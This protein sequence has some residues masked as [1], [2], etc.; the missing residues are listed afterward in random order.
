[1]GMQNITMLLKADKDAW[2]SAV[3]P[4]PCKLNECPAL[5]KIIA[6][7]V[8]QDWSPELTCRLADTLSSG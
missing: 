5:C 2:D 8:H 4:K 6:E 1:M 3:R 7:N